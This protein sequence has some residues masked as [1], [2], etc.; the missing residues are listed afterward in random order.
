MHEG[1]YEQ[2]MRLGPAQRGLLLNR[3][4]GDARVEPSYAQRRTWFLHTMVAPGPSFNLT[5][6]FRLSGP[7]DLAALG[8]AVTAIGLRHEPLRARFLDLNGSPVRLVSAAPPELAVE[9]FDGEVSEKALRALVEQ[10]ADWL[11]DVAAGPLLR[12]RAIRLGPDD[13]LLLVNTHHIASDGASLAVFY[14]ELVACYTGANLPELT[15]DYTDYVARQRDLDLVAELDF[16]R[17]E[18]A[19]APTLLDLPTDR[20]GPPRPASGSATL[21]RDGPA[22][23]IMSLKSLAHRENATPYLVLLAAFAVLLHGHSGQSDL[24]IG[25]PAAGRGPRDQGLIG[26]FANSVAVRAELTGDPVFTEALRRV[27]R[28][29]VEGY[30]HAELP[31]DLLVEHLNPT[32]V[33]GRNPLFQVFFAYESS[34]AGLTA[35]GAARARRI[36]VDERPAT[37]FD[38]SMTVV[39]HEDGRTSVRLGYPLDLF[40]ES[41]IGHLLDCY[42]RILAVIAADPERRISE[43]VATAGLQ[44]PGRV[45]DLMRG[46]PEG[47]TAAQ[48]PQAVE[49]PPPGTPTELAIAEVWRDLLDREPV[50]VLDDFFD[51]GGH[52][53][54]VPRLVHHIESRLDVRL[55]VSTVFEQPTV[56]GLAE[57][58]DAVRWLRTE[59]V[60][61]DGYE[62]GVV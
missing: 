45:A 32:R 53:L 10:E 50:G 38:L 17:R 36:E 24:L 55:T 44:R 26:L 59:A 33:S 5:E 12:C 49:S 60:V 15:S 6:A 54:L 22:D 1:T 62:E 19:G 28:S 37:W 25:T 35:L 11:F 43:I 48:R 47:W 13:H 8:R 23:V 40:D 39:A 16:W 30:G 34:R 61:P 29:A 20:P 31:H 52:S 21:D 41:S 3:I 58:V 4:A 46:L 7:L 57:A 42:L 14:R 51:L 2:V 27:R 56:R 18:L 9:E